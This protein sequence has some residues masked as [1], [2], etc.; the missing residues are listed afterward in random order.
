MDRATEGRQRIVDAA[1]RVFQRDGYETATMSRVAEAAGA[2][3]G[4]PYHYFDGKEALARAVVAQHLAVIV[5]KLAD[6]PQGSPEDRLRWFLETALGHAL[7]HQSSYRLYLTL[8]LHPATRELVM[9]EVA[10]L[11]GALAALDDGLR[12]I[13]QAFGHDEPE[14]EAIVLRATVDGLIQYLLLEPDR[15]RIGEAVD[16]ML[17]LHD[18]R[19]A[20]A[21]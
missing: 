14:T 20:A 7:A 4:L 9:E 13:F 8:A 21:G 1:A 15:F 11:G 3:K 10:R 2:S 12:Q 18:W 16:R 17:S 6:W 5:E 19:S